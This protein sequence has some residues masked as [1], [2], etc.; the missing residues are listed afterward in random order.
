[1]I[2]N[3]QKLDSD[4][5]MDNQLN[6][7]QKLKNIKTIKSILRNPVIKQQKVQKPK[8]MS[9]EVFSPLKKMKLENGW[10]NTPDSKLELVIV[11]DNML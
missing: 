8:L 2:I 6:I 10:K 1:M 7:D 11:K 9:L 4:K 5:S 3:S